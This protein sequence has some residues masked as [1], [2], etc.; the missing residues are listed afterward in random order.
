MLAI[1]SS[2]NQILAIT[3]RTG[4]MKVALVDILASGGSFLIFEFFDNLIRLLH[5]LLEY[6]VPVVDWFGFGLFIIDFQF[7]ILL[8]RLRRF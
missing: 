8:N 4:I 1:Y 3:A 2:F 5:E 6:V 7:G